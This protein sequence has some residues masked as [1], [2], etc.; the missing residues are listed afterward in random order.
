MSIEVKNTELEEAIREQ[1]AAV[2]ES[3]R[4]TNALLLAQSM[5]VDIT[6]ESAKVLRHLSLLESTVSQD[7]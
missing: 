7:D 4:L 1:T 5:K 3:I 6:K 2:R